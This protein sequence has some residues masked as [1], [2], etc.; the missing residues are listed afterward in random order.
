MR[1]SE[2]DNNSDI[3]FSA[4]KSGNRVRYS[5]EAAIR[6]VKQY[7]NVPVPL[8][9]FSDYEPG[10]GTIGMSFI[11][12]FPL[13]SIWNGLDESYK[14]RLCHETWS[15]ITQW[16][17]IPRP[18][19]LLHLYQCL[20]D[21]SPATE[22]PLLK[23]FDDPPK[24][25]CTDEALRH[26]IHQ[27]YLHYAGQQYADALPTMLPR[28]H[29]SVFTH[30]DV[31]PRNIMVDQSGHITG[32]IDWELAGWYPDYWE[33]INIM[34]PSIDNDWQTWMDRTARQRWDITGIVAARRVL[35]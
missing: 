24:A 34:K 17:Q 12:D 33:Y 13:K 20:A 4:D 32:I 11:P 5:E 21:G 27:R 22:D 9:I 10:K 30:G 28:S 25:L 16:R 15:M 14:E 26:R 18:P 7:T 1:E 29:A 23:D 6:L 2:T 8:I 35:F 19:K 3:R 31:A